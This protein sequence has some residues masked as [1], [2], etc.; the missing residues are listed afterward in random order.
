MS[1]LRKL[2][3]KVF[4]FFASPI[5]KTYWF[6]FR[7]KNRGAKCLIENS[8]EFLLIRTTYGRKIWTI[9]GGGAKKGEGLV[10]T[11]KREAYEETGLNVEKLRKIDE[12]L[13]TKEYKRDWVEIYHGYS[14]NR[15]ISIDPIEIAE[16]GWFPASNLPE[17]R[18]ARVDQALVAL[19]RKNDEGE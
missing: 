7:P 10:E 18:S 5:R 16:V 14:T 8:G 19:M 11:A 15:N 4:W 17:I 9:P 6:T 3:T 2:A 12:F 13:N 1:L